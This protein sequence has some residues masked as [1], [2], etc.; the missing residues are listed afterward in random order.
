M[1]G[2]FFSSDDNIFG[3]LIA[4]LRQNMVKVNNNYQ[5]NVTRAY[6]M[7]TNFV[8]ASPRHHHTKRTRD[9][10]NTKDR[11][12][13]GGRDHTFVQHIAPSGTVF[14]PG[15][16]SRTSYQIKYF[17]YEKCRH[18]DNQ[19]PDP[20]RDGTPN[21]SG[22][23]PEQIGRFLAQGSSGGAV[24]E[25]WLLLDSCSTIICAKNNSIVS[26]INVIPSEEHLRIYSNG[27]HIYYT[28]RGALYIVPICI[29][30]NDNS[31]VNILSMKEVAYSVRV[32]MDTK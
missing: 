4:D 15:L 13:H 8:F 25:K 32:T 9:K 28:I 6:D 20:K 26:N 14:F 19:C 11:G 18:Y 17:N 16:D 2:F 7:L 30:V 23:H 3:Y 29:Y 1:N 31:M 5:R 22:Q 24:S 10:G 21:N 12:G 27:G